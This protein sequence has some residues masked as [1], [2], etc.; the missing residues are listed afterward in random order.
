MEAPPATDIRP[1]LEALMSAAG[2]SGHEA[3]VAEIIRERWMP[4]VD[5]ISTSRLGSLQ[6]LKR[7][8]G[9]SRA[10]AIIVA[11]HMDAIG[12]I[13]T[14]VSDDVVQFDQIGGVDPR[15]LPGT[16][17]IVH[18]KRKLP[19]VVAAPPMHTVPQAERDAPL[20]LGRLV[21]DVGLPARQ[22]AQLVRVGDLISF[23]TK[24]TRLAGDTLAGHSL[25]NRA[26]V[27]AL[28]ACLAELRAKSHNWNVWAV[29]TSQEEETF[30]G[31]STSAFG[32]RPDLA[33]VIDV[34]WAKGPGASGWQTLAFAKGP[35]IVH[36]PNL[37]PYLRRRL[38]ELAEKLSIPTMDEFAPLSTGSDAEVISVTREGIPTALI[39][40]PIRYMHTPVELVAVRDVKRAGRLLAELIAS[41]EPDFLSKLSW[42]DADAD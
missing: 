33:V 37:H 18:A 25:D 19:G 11:T 29:A 36:A 13:V 12:L 8:T 41:L 40:I 2:L 28:T 39:G 9:G 6:G 35:T 21:I 27:A 22:V 20:G 38:K 16:P 30:A 31:A 42:E 10:P 5:E 32:L 26:S 4:L 7:G 1:F 23:D 3:P 24:P 34:S 14:H 15:I 17:V